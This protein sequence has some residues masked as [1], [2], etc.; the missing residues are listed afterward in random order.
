MMAPP[1]RRTVPRGIPPHR[2]TRQVERIKC[3]APA[4][5]S[6]SRTFDLGYESRERAPLRP[7]PRPSSRRPSSFQHLAEFKRTRARNAASCPPPRLAAA[8]RS[9]ARWRL[10]AA[11]CSM[12]SV[13]PDV[14]CTE[15]STARAPPPAARPIASAVFSSLACSRNRSDTI[16]RWDAPRPPA[17]RPCL[18]WCHCRP[19]RRPAGLERLERPRRPSTGSGAAAPS[20]IA[21]S[22]ARR[23]VH[24]VEAGAW[25]GLRARDAAPVRGGPRP[26]VSI[27]SVRRQPLARL[28]SDAVPHSAP[29]QGRPPRR[30]RVHR[31]SLLPPSIERGGAARLRPRASGTRVWPRCSGPTPSDDR[32][33]A[34]APS[35]LAAGRA[36]QKD[37]QQV[38][39]DASRS[40]A[41][42]T[43]RL[44]FSARAEHVGATA[45]AAPPAALSPWP[46]TA[47]TPGRTRVRRR[48]P[49]NRKTASLRRLGPRSTPQIKASRSVEE[50]SFLRPRGTPPRAPTM[51]NS[52]PSGGRTP[53][54]RSRAV[55]A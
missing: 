28:S 8:P 37:R 18:S 2:S 21:F 35:P 30:K 19:R 3:P 34:P 40:S 9:G 48:R 29:L 17:A 39:V 22:P 41:C 11:G 23:R 25:R 51:K 47:E 15:P 31:L 6:R 26:P 50:P 43:R 5:L 4:S 24:H 12:R 7:P 36:P 53:P 20:T 44:P 46:Q 27:R 1:H 32:P 10:T 38:G 42:G 49:H 13:T 33:R 54:S 45:S 14:L 16:K 52:F 55:P